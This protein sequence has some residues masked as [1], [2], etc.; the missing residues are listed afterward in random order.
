MKKYIISIIVSLTILILL[1]VCLLT[2]SQLMPNQIK[3]NNSV[4]SYTC[5]VDEIPSDNLQ[6][7][8][9]KSI[10]DS[11]LFEEQKDMILLT[12]NN[13]IRKMRILND[14]IKTYKNVR[15]G[16]SVSKIKSLFKYE[17]VN[18]AKTIYSVIFEG[19]Q[20]VQPPNTLY[21]PE[22]PNQYIIISY[23][24]ENDV[25]KEIQIYDG[26]FAVLCN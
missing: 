19:K 24:V 9:A 23:L 21:S 14:S 13:K 17:E 12:N 22:N 2:K 10:S 5:N 16:D 7:G 1:L 15:I 3:S 20:E 8:Y 25:I 18:Q 11:V 6:I 26:Q 4:I